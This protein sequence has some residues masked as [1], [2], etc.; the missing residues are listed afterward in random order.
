[1]NVLLA[2][3]LFAITF[4]AGSDMVITDT[5]V[6]SGARVSRERVEFMAIAEGL[7]AQSAGLQA[8]DIWKA[9]DTVP[10]QSSEQGR[11]I[12]AEQ[13]EGSLVMIHVE[14]EG[15]SLS[16]PVSI[17]L[18]PS[19]GTGIGIQVADK[20]FVQFPFL[21]AMA[22][23]AQFTLH[24]LQAIGVGFAELISGLIHGQGSSDVSGPIGIA[25]LTGEM[26]AQGWQTLLFF[27]AML[28]LNLAV[29]NVLPFPAL[30]GGRV[31]LLLIEWIRRRPVPAKWEQY[32][33][34]TGFALLMVLVV[35]VTVQ[36]IRQLF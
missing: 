22:Y 16:V 6:P 5:A 2:W 23:S 4:T 3:V 14:R 24:M 19:G 12:L 36:D 35:L 8:G 30:D 26:A 20:A 28:S 25:K 13:T 10:I 34:A 1:M 17:G 7:P 31:F 32:Y 21:Q 11:K 18:L 9:L 33:H 29:L 27:S 15:E